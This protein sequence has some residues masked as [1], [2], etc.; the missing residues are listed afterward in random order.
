MHFKGVQ[1]QRVLR[2]MNCSHELRCRM[3]SKSDGHAYEPAVTS[4]LSTI[5][6]VNQCFN[7]VN[8]NVSHSE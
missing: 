7:P 2:S 8:I 5:F 4:V 1:V 3:F 6:L